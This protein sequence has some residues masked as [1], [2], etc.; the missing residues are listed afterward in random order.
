MRVCLEEGTLLNNKYKITDII[1]QEGSSSII[2]KA[3]A[4]S[5][6][7]R[8]ERERSFIIKEFYPK[9][10]AYHEML[11]RSGKKLISTDE[12]S[13]QFSKELA[14][15]ME[16]SQINNICGYDSTEDARK[17][18]SQYMDGFYENGTAYIVSSSISGETLL[19]YIKKNGPAKS[20]DD[21]LKALRLIKNISY[22][23]M[24]QHKHGY[25]NLDL[26]P[27]NLY[28]SVIGESLIV[29]ILDFGSCLPF[30][31]DVYEKISEEELNNLCLRITKSDIYSNNLVKDIFRKST[32]LGW[33]PGSIFGKTLLK[34][35]LKNLSP[36]DDLFS[37]RIMLKELLH[38][39]EVV[40]KNIVDGLSFLNEAE[41]DI[42]ISLLDE[43]TE[44]QCTNLSDFISQID[45][46]MEVIDLKKISK[47]S[48]WSVSLKHFS[49][50]QQTSI[51]RNYHAAFVDSSFHGTKV[52]LKALYDETTEI[53]K[54]VLNNINENLYIHG[55]TGSGK[56]TLVADLLRTCLKTGSKTPFYVDLFD[57][58]MRLSQEE[59]AQLDDEFIF[60]VALEK[61]DNSFSPKLLC[62]EFRKICLQ[63]EYLV[64]F[65]NYHKLNM[66]KAEFI[67]LL[68]KIA[69]QF[70]NAQII[71]IG[72]EHF[73]NRNILH[74]SFHDLA[75]LGTELENIAG[76]SQIELPLLYMVKQETQSNF[77]GG[78][79]LY[80]YFFNS[81]S[82][83]SNEDT[84]S[85]NILLRQLLP[86]LAY[87]MVI[88][89]KS[90][91]K[92]TILSMLDEYA[93]SFDE[94]YQITTNHIVYLEKQGDYYR[95]SNDMFANFFAAYFISS[96]IK[97]YLN[98][99]KR[100]IIAEV[101]AYW[102]LE[103]NS[104]VHSLLPLL[105]KKTILYIQDDLYHAVEKEYT[106]GE[107]QHISHI[108]YNMANI[109]PF[110]ELIS[111]D[112]KE[113]QL[114]SRTITE[115]CAPDSL[116]YD[117]RR[118]LLLGMQIQD[119]CCY[120][121]NGIY[122]FFSGMNNLSVNSFTKAATLGD[123]RG[124]YNLSV[125][126]SYGLCGVERNKS[127][128]VYWAELATKAGSIIAANL[129][130]ELNKN[131][132]DSIVWEIYSNYLLKNYTSFSFAAIDSFDKLSIFKNDFSQI[133]DKISHMTEVE[134]RQIIDDHYTDLN[135]TIDNHSLD[136]I[137]SWLHNQPER[138]ND[139]FKTLQWNN[140]SNLN[141]TDYNSVINAL[142]LYTDV[143]LE[144]NIIA[145]M[146]KS[147]ELSSDNLVWIEEFYKEFRDAYDKERADYVFG[148]DIEYC[149]FHKKDILTEYLK[150]SSYKQGEPEWLSSTVVFRIFRKI[151][152]HISEIYLQRISV[153]DALSNAEIPTELVCDF[154]E[155]LA[156]LFYAN[157][158][159]SNAKEYFNLCIENGINNEN[160]QFKMAILDYMW[161]KSSSEMLSKIKKIADESH[162]WK[163]QMYVA[164]YYYHKDSPDFETAL[165]YYSAAAEEGCIEAKILYI[166]TLFENLKK[167]N[168]AWAELK[169]LDFITLNKQQL[170]YLHDISDITGKNNHK[171]FGNPENI[172]NK[173]LFEKLLKIGDVNIVDLLHKENTAAYE[174][175]LWNYFLSL[176]GHN[177]RLQSD[178][179]D[180]LKEL[181]FLSPD[182]YEEA[183]LLAECYIK[184]G[185]SEVAK[186]I[187]NEFSKYTPY[188]YKRLGDLHFGEI[189]FDKDIT[190][191]SFAAGMAKS[192]YKKAA[193][194]FYS[195]TYKA[196][197]LNQFFIDFP[198]VKYKYEICCG[199]SV[200]FNL[201]LLK[202]LQRS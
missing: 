49:R 36:M 176:E 46:L 113:N 129:L 85:L 126:Y 192:Y 17:A 137:I 179:P 61:Y 11:K 150:F 133:I 91:N 2:Y 25:L 146:M 33:S 165:K 151:I 5:S 73:H 67:F 161:D 69:E 125:I 7:G 123:W 107:W 37:I 41:K 121:K 32:R 13:E 12:D 200:D 119:S 114:I 82:Y 97:E 48:L 42:L 175:L 197:C 81:K 39:A 174:F 178:T 53:D 8:L 30:G 66:K 106:S 19:K 164:D 149:A 108:P 117:F 76:D 78:K 54:C 28:V 88:E 56:S 79:L 170:Q 68:Q 145:I 86:K 130:R 186:R 35:Q 98:R 62:D 4:L 109:Y 153:N 195:G 80:K 59:E 140:L 167:M 136:E 201:F 60:K 122:Q 1:S 51:Y 23:V 71:L 63:K 21:L 163:A 188:C 144:E 142:K 152:L 65:D 156:N 45:Y 100:E 9:N 38:G 134:L 90:I 72:R 172:W 120:N 155:I 111:S 29:S 131:Q 3:H 202:E 191:S 141:P 157:E 89:K 52:D 166:Y 22:A 40:S 185:E 84:V 132:D 196:D 18:N 57:L 194:T 24:E 110:N 183:F 171:V 154:A 87:T 26:K 128:A 193:T 83:M 160:I 118:W 181:G 14:V 102:D 112:V 177:S 27:D 50:Y 190:D 101:N 6:D 93:L 199:K 189:S 31:R 104:F 139:I 169:K 20:K 94:F 77:E 75:I 10:W 135:I 58:E 105:C 16:Q 99:R 138:L 187:F 182:R 168:E 70:C 180:I 198:D 43:T 124:M 95:F 127:I 159:Y 158:D 148:F 74:P 162:Y 47:H 143:L 147:I 64:V 92:A 173:L 184:I 55:E 115:L 96:K 44:G 15:F 103:I 34:E 116:L